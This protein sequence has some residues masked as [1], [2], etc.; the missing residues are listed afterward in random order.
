MWDYRA[1]ALTVL[2]GDTIRMLM[3]QGFNG[4][5]QEDIRLVNVTAPEKSEPGGP[6]TK[7]FVIDWIEKFPGEWPLRVLT[8][9]SKSDVE[10]RSFVRYLAVVY[11]I[12]GLS[13]LNNDI[14]RFLSTHPEWGKGIT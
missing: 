4:R 10:T 14:T 2:D 11:D 6:E 8:S 5:Q 3:D 13:C 1:R 12:G 9:K 7:Q